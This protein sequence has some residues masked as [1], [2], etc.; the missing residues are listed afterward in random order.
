MSQKVK[1]TVAGVKQNTAMI[2]AD[3]FL[4]RCSVV[5]LCSYLVITTVVCSYWLSVNK[6][7]KAIFSSAREIIGMDGSLKR[8]KRKAK[9]YE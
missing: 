8:F 5:V 3:L 4:H 6:A 7:L 2:A 1:E 9:S